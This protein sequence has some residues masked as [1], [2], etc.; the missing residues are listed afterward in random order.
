MWFELMVH[1][2]SSL[3]KIHCGRRNM[4]KS[5]LVMNETFNL[6]KDLTIPLCFHSRLADEFRGVA[7]TMAIGSH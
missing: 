3:D 5:D 2:D 4:V 7:V 1:L 6:I